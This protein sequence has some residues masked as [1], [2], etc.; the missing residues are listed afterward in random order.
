MPGWPPTP[1]EVRDLPVDV[2][3]VRLLRHVRETGKTP[4]RNVVANLRAQIDAQRQRQAVGIT[5][6]TVIGTSSAPLGEDYESGIAE[7]WHW[8]ISAG[9]L[10]EIPM[11]EHCFRVSRLGIKL[12]DE[13]PDPVQHARAEQR[14]GLDLHPLIR[15]TVRSQFLLGEHDAAV[16]IAFRTVEE[17]VRELAGV[18]NE[19]L[20]VN[21]MKKAFGKDGPLRDQEVLPAEADAQ[22]ALFWGAIGFFK[23]PASHRSVQ[24]EDVT[25]AAEAVLFADLLLRILDRV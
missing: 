5:G 13:A 14:I 3:G 17:R 11:E 12:L 18:G 21:L 25:E 9:L 19:E 2:I 7:A 22:M 24:Y 4:L 16:L 23:N 8:L 15:T 6:G 10:T 1:E 20:G